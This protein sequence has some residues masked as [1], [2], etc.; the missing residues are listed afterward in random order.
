MMPGPP[1]VQTTKRLLLI[2]IDRPFGDAMR[3]LASF[4]VVT[5]AGAGLEGSRRAEEHDGVADFFLAEMRERIEVFAQDAQRPG[6]G[7][8]EELLVPVGEAAGALEYPS[9]Q[10]CGKCF[11]NCRTLL[12]ISGNFWNAV[13]ARSHS[14]ASNAGDPLT[15]A[16]AGTSWP[17]PLC[18]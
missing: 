4:V 13:M 14:R 9:G 12:S 6:I 8:I 17:M 5:P 2:Q 15:A 18:A 7:R 16:P 11:S 10:S 3:E 1:P